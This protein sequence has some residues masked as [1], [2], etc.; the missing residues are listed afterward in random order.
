MMTANALP[1]D[2]LDPAVVIEHLGKTYISDKGGAPKV[3]LRDVSLTIPQGSILGLLGP[4][5]AGKSTLINIMAGLVTKTSGRVVI[6]G[7]DLDDHPV[8]I[9]RHIGIVP[10]EIN[11]DPFFTPLE[12]LEFQAGFF[13]IRH[14]RAR[15]MGILEAL[16]LADKANITARSLSG[17]MKRRLMVAKAMVH[18]P[19]VLVLDEPTAGV[20]IELRQLLWQY[21][22]RLNQEEG[23]TVLLTTHYLEEAQQMCDTIAIIHKGALRAFEKTDSL[24]SKIDSKRLILTFA[25]PLEAV[26]SFLTIFQPKQLSPTTLALDYQPNPEA[27]QKILAAIA[28]AKLDIAD[29]ETKQGDLEDIFLA[30]TRQD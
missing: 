14:R 11:M 30:F 2:R 17:G 22:R 6:G 4:N 28:G 19:R 16:G 8:E 7:M 27:I 12:I 25:H 29:I 15:A 18:Q 26:P 13:G 1:Q 5:G 3:A 10:Q 24:L 9:R 20:D 23:V 21:V